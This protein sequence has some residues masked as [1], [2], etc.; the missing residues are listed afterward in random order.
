MI[1]KYSLFQIERFKGGFTHNL[2]RDDEETS[3]V[4]SEKCFIF[5]ETFDTLEEAQDN[6]KHIRENTIILPSY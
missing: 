1:Q 5:L 2:G 4:D 6:A 3:T